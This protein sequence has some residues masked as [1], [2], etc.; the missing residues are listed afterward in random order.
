MYADYSNELKGIAN[1]ARLAGA[2]TKRPTASPQA[3]KV[4]A[5]EIKSLDAKILQ[6][7]QQKPREREAL[8]AAQHAANARIKANPGM[9]DELKTKVRA[10]QLRV[11]RARLGVDRIDIEVT[12]KEWEAI[13]AN[14]ISPHKLDKVLA[15]ADMETIKQL[16]TPKTSVLMTDAK[17]T[18]ARQ[19][20]KNDYTAAE[21]AAFLGVSVSTLNRGLKG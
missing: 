5:N 3:K 6:Y 8:I 12:P 21:V 2:R 9:S 17:V 20:L 4:Y 14:A 19:L 13:Q 15:R 10:Q 1:T 18:R 7:D 16:A 11:T